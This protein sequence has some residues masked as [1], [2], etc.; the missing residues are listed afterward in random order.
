VEGRSAIRVPACGG[1]TTSP[2]L[3]EGIMDTAGMPGPRRALRHIVLLGCAVA[4]VACEVPVEQHGL[5]AEADPVERAAV[6]AVVEGFFDALEDRDPDA[7]RDLLLPGGRFVSMRETEAGMRMADQTH[8]DF[9]AQLGSIEVE[10]LERYWNP[11]VHIHRDIAMVWTPYDFFVD[12][13]FSHCG[14][15]A[16]SLVRVDG[17]WRIATAVYTVETSGCEPS[18]LGPPE[19]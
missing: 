1:R 14:V 12:R 17:R 8:E 13:E 6:L 15:D 3:E 19:F 2:E 18:P 16:F 11:V 7:A 5:V 10:M 4:A 9:V